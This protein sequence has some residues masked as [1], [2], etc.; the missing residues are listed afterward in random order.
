VEP[1]QRNDSR[2]ISNGTSKVTGPNRLFAQILDRT[3]ADSREM[4]H[5][6]YDHVR[7]LLRHCWVWKFVDEMDIMEDMQALARQ[8]WKKRA[9]ALAGDEERDMGNPR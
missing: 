1:E 9:G 7:M 3:V 4:R 5:E 6:H 2:A 8:Q